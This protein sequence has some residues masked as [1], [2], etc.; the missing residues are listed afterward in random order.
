MAEKTVEWQKDGKK[1][2]VTFDTDTETIIADPQSE[3]GY[4]VIKIQARKVTQC[5]KDL[6][7]PSGPP[8]C[9]EYNPQTQ[10]IVYDSDSPGG[11][12]V[13]PKL[14]GSIVFPTPDRI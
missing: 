5:Y 9:Y 12:K 10:V 7:N 13:I 2:K 3:S 14:G 11:V 1:W 4:K 6:N 8:I